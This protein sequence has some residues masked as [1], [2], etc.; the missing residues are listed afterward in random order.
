MIRYII[1]LLISGAVTSFFFTGVVLRIAQRFNLLDTPSG[2][3]IHTKGVPRLGGIA[4]IISF[5]GCLFLTFFW[6]NTVICSKIRV[7]FPL[8]IPALIIVALGIF[9]DVKGANAVQKFS[10]QIACACLV[11][12]FSIRIEYLSVPFLGTIP[13]GK[14]SL[15]LTVLWIVLSINAFNLIDGLDGLLCRVSIYAAGSLA[16]VF[17][18]TG[19]AGMAFILLLL[20]GTLIGFLPWNLYPAKIFMGDTGSMFIGFVFAVLSMARYHK[21]AMAMSLAIPLMILFVPL[22]DTGWAFLRRVAAG[23]SPFKSDTSHIHHR[24]FFKYGDHRKASFVL[25]SIS[26]G[27]SALGIIAAFLGPKY[28]TIFVLLALTSGIGLLVL[29]R[30]KEEERRA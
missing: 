28:R 18:I 22:F 7:L 20:I 6:T 9:D 27:F 30:E 23:K 24:F 17:F 21:G 5:F 13:L 14:F 15:L 25:S 26:G 1:I 10:V 2:G 19:N 3:K 11:Y 8:I 12:Y 16:V 4:L 29:T